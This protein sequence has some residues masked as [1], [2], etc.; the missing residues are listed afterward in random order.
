M[1]T[2]TSRLGFT[3]IELLVVIAV[4]AILIALLVPAVQK[5]RAAAANTQCLNNLHQLGLALH[6]YMDVNKAV[7]P[8][9]V[10]TYNSTTNAVVQTSPWSAL[11]QILPYVEQGN[12]YKGIIFTSP[13]SSQPN[14]TSKRIP[15]FICPNEVNDRGSGTDPIYGNKNW[16]LNYAVNMGTW[17]VLTAKTTTMQGSDGAFSSNFGCTPAMFK[18]GMSCTLAMSEVK[19]YTNRLT[20]SPDNVVYS[21]APPPPTSPADLMPSPPFGLPGLSPAA[22]NPASFTHAEWVDGKVH[23]TGFTTAFTPNTVVPYV[24]GGVKYDVDFISITETKLGD[25]YAAVTSRS[26]HTGGTVN[27]LLMDGSARTVGSTISLHTWRA[28]GTRAGADVAM[29]Y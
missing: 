17:G 28:L 27:I 11:S 5:V 29:D 13:Y 6:G 14:I 26:Y 21:L 23:E 1:R 2:R 20:G 9:G 19:G 25:T 3:L 24:S 22:F 4:M 15:V 18:D 8:N 7:P 16:T 10:Y 12:L